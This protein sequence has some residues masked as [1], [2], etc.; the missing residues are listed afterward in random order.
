MFSHD[1][2]AVPQICRPDAGCRWVT[3]VDMAPHRV[4]PRPTAPRQE[5]IASGDRLLTI[6]LELII[7]DKSS[8]CAAIKQLRNE[9][10]RGARG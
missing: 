1:S 7:A 8:P 10:Q 3:L 4:E 2:V 5:A 6:P 9:L